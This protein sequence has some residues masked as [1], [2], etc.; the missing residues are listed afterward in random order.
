MTYIAGE[1]TEYNAG[2]DGA[3][4]GDTGAMILMMVTRAQSIVMMV[5]G[6]LI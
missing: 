6:D 4:D 3:T 5:V 2:D 1:G